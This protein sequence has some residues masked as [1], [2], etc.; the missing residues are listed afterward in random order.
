MQKGKELPMSREGRPY[1]ES[2]VKLYLVRHAIAA[3]RG[4]EWSD[5]AKRPLTSAGRARFRETA[6]GLARLGVRV[7]V[8]LTSPLVRARETADIVCAVMPHRPPIVETPWL[9][10]GVPISAAIDALGAHDNAESMVVVGHEPGIGEMAARLIGA[11]T[12]VAFK[13]GAVCRIDFESA[14]AAASGQLRWF[15]T[16]KIARRL[17]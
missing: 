8:I 9:A 13:K 11:R 17:R 14:P 6:E 10:P 3:Q 2:H 1:S 15:I 4:D 5:D 7:E 12:P 16:P